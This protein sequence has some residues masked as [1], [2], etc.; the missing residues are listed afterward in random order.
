MTMGGISGPGIALPE[1]A[2]S[3]AERAKIR[4]GAGKFEALLI[5]QMLKTARESGSGG[6]LGAGESQTDSTMLEM[7]EECFAEVLASRGGLGLGK[8]VEQHLRPQ[9]ESGKSSK[10]CCGAVR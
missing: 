7:A 3:S 10:G 9:G 1:A 8:L 6:M 2:G 4:D 5:A